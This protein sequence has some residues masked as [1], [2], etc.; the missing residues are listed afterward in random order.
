MTGVWPAIL[1]SLLEFES[2]GSPA[3]S[4]NVFVELA[5]SMR[6]HGRS[7][8]LCEGGIDHEQFAR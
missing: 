2:P 6:A 5:V 7:G 4:V 1:G 3:D 8:S